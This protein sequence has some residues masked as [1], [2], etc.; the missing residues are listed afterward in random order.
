MFDPEEPEEKDK[1]YAMDRDGRRYLLELR[2]EPQYLFKEGEDAAVA[3]MRTYIPGTGIEVKDKY[4]S[5]IAPKGQPRNDYSEKDRFIMV[6]VM[7]D[8]LHYY[9][10]P[11]DDRAFR[12]NGIAFFFDVADISYSIEVD[13]F[14]GQGNT[15]L[16]L[17]NGLEKESTGLVLLQSGNDKFF[18]TG[19]DE[20]LNFLKFLRDKTDMEKKD[21]KSLQAEWE[22][23]DKGEIASYTTTFT[24][25]NGTEYYL[26]CRKVAFNDWIMAG[27]VP[28]DVVNDSMTNIRTITII[29]MAAIFIV[30]GGGITW[31]IIMS[32]KRKIQD[33]ELAIKSRE[34]LFDHITFNSKDIFAL[35]DAN[36][37]EAE[38]VSSNVESVLGIPVEE[39]KKDVYKILEAATVPA[40]E[41]LQ[42]SAQVLSE[43]IVVEELCMKN[44]QDN[45]ETWY[46]LVINPPQGKSGYVLMLFDRTKERRMRADL[47]SALAIAKSANEAKSNFLSNMSHDIRTPMNA[48]IGFATLLEKDAENPDKVRDYIR[49]ISFS[50]HHM[51]SLIND[52]LDMSKI[53]SGKSALHIEEFAL[54][55]MLEEIYTII[56]TQ[57]ASKK[58]KF[59]M[60]TKGAIPELVNGDRLRLNQVMINLLSNAVK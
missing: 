15:F 51:L 40:E 13:A 18:K 19:E 12:Y 21:I 11:G 34:G 41:L 44:A 29:V 22:R 5:V 3:C 28:A 57:V 32:N 58:Q 55:D 36:M 37:G 54:P 48:I 42:N 1:L 38:Y 60:H 9:T 17:P 31:F 16:V 23:I 45:S 33:K 25:N 6:A 56:S 43:G 27:V 35:F 47:E 52:I 26:N 20:Q 30:L 2:R 49:K 14:D 59:E 7:F 4:G 46:R 10:A 53:E 39:A 8:G 50:S 24:G